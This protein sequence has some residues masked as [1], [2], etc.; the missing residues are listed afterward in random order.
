MTKK[1]KLAILLS[2]LVLLA[3]A[4]SYLLV[5]RT[6]TLD[7]KNTNLITFYPSPLGHTEFK[8][9]KT[10]NVY[11]PK[12]NSGDVQVFIEN[13]DGVTLHKPVN[14]SPGKTIEVE[15]PKRQYSDDLDI[16]AIAL[17]NEGSYAFNLTFK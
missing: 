3:I 14:V 13:S 2:L 8:F 9:V 16:L 4:S 11:S 12:E 10:L 6:S 1:N 15:L 17:E 7:I 5:Y